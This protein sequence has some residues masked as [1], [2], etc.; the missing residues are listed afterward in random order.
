[1][2]SGLLV[3]NR[4]PVSKC[5]EFISYGEINITKFS[6]VCY[7]QKHSKKGKFIIFCECLNA[8]LSHPSPRVSMRR[9]VDENEDPLENGYNC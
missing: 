8:L 2:L 9:I 4:N 3:K 7:R 6:F 5:S 1:M